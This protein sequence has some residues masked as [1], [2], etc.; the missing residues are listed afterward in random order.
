ME[1]PT[2]PE[3][4]EKLNVKRDEFIVENTR[5]KWRAGVFGATAWWPALVKL[6]ADHLGLS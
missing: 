3:R 4:G 2:H 6:L 5:R 1:L